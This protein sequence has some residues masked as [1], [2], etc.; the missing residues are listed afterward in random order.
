[1]SRPRCLT[2]TLSVDNVLHGHRFELSGLTETDIDK[3]L[4]HFISILPAKLGAWLIVL[5]LVIMLQRRDYRCRDLQIGDVPIG[6][7]RYQDQRLHGV[8]IAF[9]AA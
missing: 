4:T 1:M 5:P 8:R 9:T 2:V 6:E 3:V 7:G